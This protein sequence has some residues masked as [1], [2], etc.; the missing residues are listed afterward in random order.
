MISA[1]LNAKILRKSLR[2]IKVCFYLGSLHLTGSYKHRLQAGCSWIMYE[3]RIYF[4]GLY[5]LHLLER[6]YLL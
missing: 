5:Y 1:Q 3:L 2:V 4:V 6:F